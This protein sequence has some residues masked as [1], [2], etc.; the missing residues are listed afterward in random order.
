MKDA[1]NERLRK[2]NVFLC[3]QYLLYSNSRTL[4]LELL[5]VWGRR[6]QDLKGQVQNKETMMCTCVY[7]IHSLVL[8]SVKRGEVI[9][10]KET[11]IPEA[12]WERGLEEDRK[13]TGT[14]RLYAKHITRVIVIGTRP[15][16]NQLDQ[17]GRWCGPWGGSNYRISQ[18][19]LEEQNNW[20]EDWKVKKINTTNNYIN[21]YIDT[22]MASIHPC[23]LCGWW[24]VVY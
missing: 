20:M 12:R 13:K 21:T 9:G 1:Q 8:G 18:Y 6:F 16:G 5:R 23:I 14:K 11:T 3:V 7:I 10:K 24:T 4:V 15:S 22:C 2:D 17:G 19:R